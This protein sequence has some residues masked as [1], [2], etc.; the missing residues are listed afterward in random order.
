MGEC[1]PVEERGIA[2]QTAS[3]LI[4]LG[5]ALDGVELLVDPAADIRAPRSDWFRAPDWLP[6]LMNAARAFVT[7][8]LAELFW[9]ATAWPNGA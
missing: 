9:I 3:A 8:G 1:D 2:D 6:S 7:I 5:R 4:G